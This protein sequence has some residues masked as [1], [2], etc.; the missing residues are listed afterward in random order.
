MKHLEPVVKKSSSYSV[1]FLRD[2]SGVVR[3]R[4][5][6]G[7]IKFLAFLL[8][9]FCGASGASGYAAHYYWKKYQTLQLERMELAEKLGENRRQL[10][11]FAGMEKIKESTLP[12]STMAGVTSIAGGHEGP[13]NQENGETVIASDAAPNGTAP[14]GNGAAPEPGEPASSTPPE[15]AGS[16]PPVPDPVGSGSPPGDHP[17]AGTVAEAAGQTAQVSPGTE[18]EHPA[19]ITEVL[20]RP[21][22]SKTFR[23]AFDLS[24]RDQQVTLNGRVNLAVGTKNGDRHEV[25]QVSR[26][27]LRFIINRY[28]RVN[29]SFILPDGVSADDVTQLFLTVVADDQSPVTY[30]FSFPSSS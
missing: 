15:T 26:D 28:K 4:L 13:E 16:T 12:R 8:V 7:W 9:V 24:N 3:F 21:A 19:L 2:D 20:V 18:E 23:L 11:R 10:G 17:A 6:P 5:K 30:A 22:G 14:H 27:T 29:T 1:L 25:T